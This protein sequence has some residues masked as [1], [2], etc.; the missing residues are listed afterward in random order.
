MSNKIE[1]EVELLRDLVDAAGYVSMFYTMFLNNETSENCGD[2][3]ATSFLA[4]EA[5]AIVERGLAVLE[6]VEQTGA[7]DASPHAAQSDSNQGSRN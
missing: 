1:I 2:F 7:V 6:A 4:S 5:S 3:D